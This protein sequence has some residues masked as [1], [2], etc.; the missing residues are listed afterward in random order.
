[1]RYLYRA[2]MLLG[3]V[4]AASAV[5]GQQ[6]RATYWGTGGAETIRLNLTNCSRQVATHRV[7]AG[8]AHACTA[9]AR[10]P[11]VTAEDLVYT[12][13]PGEQRSVLVPVYCGNSHVPCPTDGMPYHPPSAPYPRLREIILLRRDPMATQL[14]IWNETDQHRLRE[15][16]PPTLLETVLSGGRVRA[17]GAPQIMCVASY[18]SVPATQDT[19]ASAG[20]SR[21]TAQQANVRALGWIGAFLC[22]PLPAA[23]L[24]CLG[25]LWPTRRRPGPHHA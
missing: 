16:G 5:L 18:A 25:W 6:V 12:L 1:M 20:A 8:E 17:H 9:P 19:S 23:L 24:F 2:N 15:A 10:Q 4:L 13:A 22:V 3:A 11:L 21:T 14:L 7:W